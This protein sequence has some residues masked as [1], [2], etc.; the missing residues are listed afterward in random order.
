MTLLAL[1]TKTDA[2]SLSADPFLLCGL[3]RI[4]GEGGAITLP[5][6]IRGVK[7]CEAVSR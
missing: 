4:K 5:N 6:P 3:P 7:I 1:Q 2:M